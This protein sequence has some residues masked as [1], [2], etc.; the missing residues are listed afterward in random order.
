MAESLRRYTN[1]LSLLDMLKSEKLT[2]LPPQGGL[3]KTML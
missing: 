2:L 3:I 1:V